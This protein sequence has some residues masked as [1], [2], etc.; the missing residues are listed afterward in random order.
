[1]KERK[2]RLK[3]TR[4]EQ[5]RLTCWP[6]LSKSCGNQGCYLVCSASSADVVRKCCKNTM[7]LAWLVCGIVHDKETEAMRER[8]MRKKREGGRRKTA[9]ACV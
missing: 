8:M 2:G 1:M 3:K 7:P 4:T 9:A 6:G 5:H